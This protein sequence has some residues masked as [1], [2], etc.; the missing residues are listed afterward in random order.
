MLYMTGE[1]YSSTPP[2]P[3]AELTEGCFLTWVRVE[4]HLEKSGY[5]HD[6]GKLMWAAIKINQPSFT[7][8]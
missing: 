1:P 7:S 3:L 6:T 4:P 2:E 8:F 5:K